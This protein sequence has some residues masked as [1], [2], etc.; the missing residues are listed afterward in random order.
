MELRADL[1]RARAAECF[2]AAEKVETL[3]VRR[4]YLELRRGWR[5]LA[6]EIEHLDRSR[7]KARAA[8]SGVPSYPHQRHAGAPF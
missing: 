7:L 4:A 1:F 3:A 2:A 6:D 8:N 5:E